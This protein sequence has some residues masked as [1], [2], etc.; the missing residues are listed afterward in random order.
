[1]NFAQAGAFYRALKPA[2]KADLVKNLAGDLN[3]VTSARTKTI[4]VSYFTQADAD[5]G[6]RL[7]KAVNVSPAEVNRAVQE[8]NAANPALVA[9]A[10]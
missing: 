10:N 1:N 7:A 4:M 9:A 8:Y 6:A 3:V 2:D 5:L